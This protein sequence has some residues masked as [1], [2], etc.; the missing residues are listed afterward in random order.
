MHTTS[1]RSGQDSPTN[2]TPASPEKQLAQTRGLT[3]LGSECCFSCIHT[4]SFWHQPD[5]I[6]SIFITNAVMKPHF[7]QTEVVMREL[8]GLAVDGGGEWDA[9]ERNTIQGWPWTQSSSGSLLEGKGTDGVHG[10]ASS[11]AKSI[12]CFSPFLSLCKYRG[13]AG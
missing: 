12:N 13:E 8:G 11:E 7:V 5:V 10:H 4:H 3:N 6:Y 2:T 9:I 1:L